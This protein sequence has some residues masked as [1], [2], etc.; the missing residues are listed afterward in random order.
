MNFLVLFIIFITSSCVSHKYSHTYF[1]DCEQRFSGFNNLY[2][3]A[4]EEL[5]NDCKN[6]S[7][8]QSENSRFVEIIKRIKLMVDSEEISENE[9]M[10][11]YLNLIDLEELKFKP[12][13]NIYKYYQRNYPIYFND[14]YSRG[15][16]TCLFSSSGFCY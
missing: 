9:A 11:R 7:N 1:V 13:N 6:K 16:S 12:S 10:F 15:N 14:F 2:F 8:C 3:C 4:L 5:Q